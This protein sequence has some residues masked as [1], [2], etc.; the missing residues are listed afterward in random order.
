MHYN[1]LEIISLNFFK[2]WS[3]SPSEMSH[4]LRE[5]VKD[6]RKAG[7]RDAMRWSVIIIIV[8]FIFSFYHINNYYRK[9]QKKC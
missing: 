6:Q 5:Q 2:S 1:F 7:K 8:F 3:F 9:K 4:R